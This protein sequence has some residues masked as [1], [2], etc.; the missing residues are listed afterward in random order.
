MSESPILY[1]DNAATSW[2]KPEAVTDAMT[3]FVREMGANPG[4]SGHRLSVEAGRTVFSA[5]EAVCDLFDAPDPLRVCFTHNVTEALN[6]ALKGLLRP[7]NHVITS[8]VEH[9]SMMRPLRAL[10]KEGVELT[11]VPCSPEGVL[12]P[13]QVEEA[14]Q[15]NTKIIAMTHA[16]NVMGTIL[17]V[18]EVGAIARRRGPLFLLD[19]AATA[20]VTPIRMDE[21]GIDLLAFTGHKAM[22]G[23]TGTGG[24]VVGDR[25]ELE[26]FRPLKQGGTGSRSELEEQ[27]EF[28]PDHFESG[29]LNAMGLA[30][31]EAGIRWV[32]D[33]GLDTI[34]AH[35]KSL[36]RDL[37]E[38]LRG[39][40]GVTVYGTGDA[41]RQTSTVSIGLKG[42][43]PSEAGL[44][45]DEEYGILC[46]VGLHC[47]PAAHRT[48]GTL[49]RGTIRF[50]P[51][52]FTTQKDV[53]AV[54][55]AVAQ[56]ARG[57][58]R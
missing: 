3:R 58:T 33:R 10:E 41:G 57:N 31:L 50:A 51:G 15:P 54:L 17:P 34:R 43:S 55:N 7:G 52:V 32:L 42:L 9:N 21:V 23:P 39:I 38:G 1:L 30:G 49:P 5:R 16:S 22:L 11:V 8:S 47:A 14:I 53:Q 48:M 44:M 19:A 26:A 56:L 18:T 46:R 13:R 4:R 29:T 36:C 35:H 6:L 2:P 27:P 20:G 37:L 24:L 25:V 28:L 40:A 12:D 45:L